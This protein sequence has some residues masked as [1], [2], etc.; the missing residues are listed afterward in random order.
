MST[1]RR[2][3]AVV[4]GLAATVAVSALIVAVAPSR[5]TFRGPERSDRLLTT[6]GGAQAALHDSPD[7]R[8]SL[9]SRGCRGTRAVPP[10]LQRLHGSPGR[11]SFETAHEVSR[12]SHPCI[13]RLVVAEWKQILF[14]TDASGRST[15]SVMN[16][17]G[18]GVGR[19]TRAAPEPRSPSWGTQR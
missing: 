8:R 5:A 15:L 19:L 1:S 3:I 18:S 10:L 14:R 6:D 12:R 17:D 13:R 2:R 16:A 4:M 9:R 7:G 11:R